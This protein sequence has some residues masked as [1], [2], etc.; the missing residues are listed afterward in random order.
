MDS[1][2]KDE[3]EKLREQIRYHDRKYYVD[4]A[5][6]IS[7]REYD[8]LLERLKQFEAEHPEL[9]TPDSPTQRV[10]GEPIEGFVTVEHARR[11]YSIDNTYERADLMAWHNRVVKGLG[12][13]EGERLSYVAEPKIDGVA[14][15]LRYE[16]GLLVLGATRGDG[17]RGDDITQNIR[18]IRAIPLRLA[19]KKAPPPVLE[20]R[21]E[22]YMPAAEFAR[23]NQRRTKAGEEPLANPRNATAGTLKLHDSRTVAKR[24]LGFIA[25]GSGE[26]TD[27]PFTSYSELLDALR[28][29]G[30]PTNPLTRVCRSIDEVWQVIEQFDQQRGDLPYGVDGVVVKVDREDQREALG[31]TSKFP[32][33]C[34]AYKYAAEQAITKLLKVDWQV[35]K[36]GKLTPRATMEPVFL[37]GTTVQHATLH[38]LGEILRKDIRLSDTVVIE[39]AGEIIPQVVSVVTERRDKS[40][41]PIQ[42]PE[43]CPECNGDVE[44]EQDS[45]G[46]ETARYCINPE[47]PAQ[48]RER[49]IYFAGRNQMDIRGLGEEIIDQL[50]DAGLVSHFSDLYKLET[51]QLA[52]LTRTTVKEGKEIKVRLGEKNATRIVDSLEDSKKRGLGRVLAS[53]GIRHI[54]NETARIIASNVHDIDELLSLSLTETRLAVSEA[55]DV[56]QI[57]L[58]R[59]LV[60]AFFAALHS[61]DGFK[62]I[63]EAR[64][65]AQIE[66]SASEVK[67]FLDLLPDGGSTWRVKWGKGQGKKDLILKNFETLDDLWNAQVDDLVDVFV[68]DV[69][70][71]S[72]YEFLHSESGRAAIE[73]LRA[74]GV[75]MTSESRPTTGVHGPLANKVIVVTGKLERYGSREEV[76]DLIRA[77]G[78]RPATSVTTKTDFLLAGESGGNKID[79]ARKFGIP[80]INEDEFEALL[81]IG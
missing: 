63:D 30:V 10:G 67:L 23:I 61:A 66:R 17:Q 74:A 3:I 73:S 41:K 38:N 19:G 51:A 32:R 76:H 6:E 52:A 77:N 72:L 80:V 78:G 14:V 9:V 81:G 26:I 37:A 55:D 8:G 42:P 64:R 34:I 75:A 70:G 53:L 22:I 60:D 69:I 39:K 54:G 56:K 49:L 15:S 4:A 44:A 33:W 36:T 24:Q 58:T 48:F 79:K 7:D 1:R 11:M 45:A 13:S 12:L 20:V 46:K 25:H 2:V 43:K 29:W 50:L 47:C 31:F 18:T 21:G 35:G 27:A 68:E 65:K 57:R 5:P 40:V 16:D 28:D 71:R 62:R 59:K